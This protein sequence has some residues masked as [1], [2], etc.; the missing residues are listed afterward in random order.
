M[1]V[2]AISAESTVYVHGQN[3]RPRVIN[4]SITNSE[5]VGIFVNNNAQVTLKDIKMRPAVIS[6]TLEKM[7]L[8]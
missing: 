3:A 1:T 8:Y 4:C 5:N 6:S 2:H 7:N